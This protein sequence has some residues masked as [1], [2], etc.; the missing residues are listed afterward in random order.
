MR[1]L[2]NVSVAMVLT[3]FAPASVMAAVS[4]SATIVGT[5]TLTGADGSTWLSLPLSRLSGSSSI[6]AWYRCALA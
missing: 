2:L 1:S 5:V 3:A 4:P 6:S